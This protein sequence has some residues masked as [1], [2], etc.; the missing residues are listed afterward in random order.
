MT[1]DTR[2]P[3]SEAQT[4]VFGNL[5]TS[6]LGTRSPR[7]GGA[8]DASPPKGGASA[9]ASAE[10][11]RAAPETPPPPPPPPAGPAPAAK[12]AP[13]GERLGGVEDLA[14]AGVAVAAQAAT[15]GVRAASRAL[16]ALRRSVDRD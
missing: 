12:P 9:A 10:P 8:G 6:R 14:W 11:S 15:T 16:E 13:Q 7:R 4:G 2:E 3:P 5:P 1:D